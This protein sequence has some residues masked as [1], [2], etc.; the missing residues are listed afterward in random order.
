MCRLANV[1]ITTG[2]AVAEY[3]KL[4]VAKLKAELR[5]RGAVITGRKV[6]LIERCVMVSV[7]FCGVGIGRLHCKHVSLPRPPSALGEIVLASYWH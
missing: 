1:V 7:T 5:R 3:G 2:E 6:D 4:T